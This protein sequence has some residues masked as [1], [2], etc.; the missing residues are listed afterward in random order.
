MKTLFESRV[1]LGD[2]SSTDDVRHYE[3]D[4]NLFNNI[5]SKVYREV[6]IKH[7]VNLAKHLTGVDFTEEQMYALTALFRYWLHS[8]NK[9]NL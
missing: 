2:W 1:S 4:T 9:I 8:E 6:N 3:M 7:S 5:L